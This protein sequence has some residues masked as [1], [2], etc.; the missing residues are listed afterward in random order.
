MNGVNYSLKL[1]GE[2]RLQGNWYVDGFVD[3]NN[4]NDYKQA[5]M[6]LTIRYLFDTPAWNPENALPSIPDWKGSQ[7][8]GLRD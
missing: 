1:R 2:Y 6:G 5:M 3:V 8:L 7:P 4:A